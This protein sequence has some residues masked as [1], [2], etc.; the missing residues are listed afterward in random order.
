MDYINFDL[1]VS[2]WDRGA[3][4]AVVEVLNSPAGESHRLSVT[5][6]AEPHLGP[7][8]IYTTPAMAREAGQALARSVMPEQ[9]LSLWQES[10]QIARAR[11]VGLRLRLHLDSPELTL[12]PW[13]LLYDTRQDDFLVFDEQVSVVRYMRLQTAPPALRPAES[14]SIMAIVAMPKDSVPLDT[15]AEVANL[16][17]A[18]SDLVQ[19]QRVRLVICEQATLPKLSQMLLEHAP[20]IVH[21]IGHASYDRE[22]QQGLMVLEDERGHAAPLTAQKMA[23]LLR[24]YGSN[25][26]VLNACETAVGA[27]AGLGP[28]LVRADIPAVVAMQWPVEDRAATAFTRAFYSA[29]S[30]GRTIDECV[31]SGRVGV[32]VISDYPCDWAAPV[33]FLR[34]DSGCLWMNGRQGY[35]PGAERSPDSSAAPVSRE[36]REDGLRGGRRKTLFK[37]HGPLSAPEDRHLIIERTALRQALRTAQ[38]PSVTQYI[39]LLSARQT[40]KTTFLLQLMD[41]LRDTYACVFVDMAMLRAQD[42]DTA[43]RLLASRLASALGAI[44]GAAYP[45]PETARIQNPVEFL[46][47]LEALAR[48]APMSRI[49]VLVDEVGALAPEAAD[50]FFNALRS[51]FTQGRSG[52]GFLAKY[53]FVF[54]GA[55]DLYGLTSGTTSPLNIC[56]KLYLEDFS[57][58]DVRRLLGLFS[59]LH[60]TVAKDAAERLYAHTEGHPYLT[61]RICALMEA[62]GVAHVS[63]QA[64]EEAAAQILVEDDNIRHII[65]EL[66]RNPLGRRRLHD[67]LVARREIAFTRNDPVLAAL[68]MLGVIRAAQPCRMRNRLYATAMLPYVQGHAEEG[69]SF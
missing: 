25:L 53:L 45:L 68:E 5:L 36:G 38:Q 28:A 10:R 33:L 65:G 58:A 48:A 67:I 35:A 43:F 34:S 20:D 2:E 54:S 21:F 59:H 14:F 9:I 55:V 26:V 37:T 13:E 8:C 56:E 42:A 63:A 30:L 18:L 51:V 3:Q 69:R 4:R 32:N 62:S 6:D 27:W 17:A 15:A 52:N 7:T 29:L 1:R 24:Q 31:A 19:A 66:E 50:V 44:L 40:G 49:L 16:R 39:A 61:M 57:L 60:A 41:R 46:E 12:L 11:E 64:I 22:T 47:F 23:R